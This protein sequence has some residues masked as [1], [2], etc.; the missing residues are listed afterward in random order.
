MRYL[1]MVIRTPD[2]QQSAIETHKAYLSQLREN[3]VLELAGPFTD[4]TGGA[5]VIKADDFEAASA[6]AFADPIYTSGSSSVF[7]YEWDAN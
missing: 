1:V 3:G 2:F 5:Y 4:S 6:I 7:I